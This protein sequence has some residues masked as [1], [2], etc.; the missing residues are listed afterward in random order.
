MSA[1]YPNL[2]T[3]IVKRGIKKCAI[4][5]T[6]GISGRS[7]Y[8]KMTGKVSFTWPE[9]CTIRDTFF[10]DMEKDFLF[11]RSSHQKDAS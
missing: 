10:P 8:N 6:L 11:A 4:A 3:E 2:A 1:E 9:T 7:L 5:S